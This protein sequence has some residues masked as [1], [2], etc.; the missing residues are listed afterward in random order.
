MGRKTVAAT[1]TTSALAMISCCAHYLANIVPILGI[2]GV[3]SIVA[4]YQIKIFWIG[5][6]SN[7]LGIVFIT[8][9]IIKFPAKGLPAGRQASPFSGGKKTIV[10]KTIIIILLA[11]VFIG[12]F[13][14]VYQSR[15]AEQEI[16]NNQTEKQNSTQNWETKTDGQANVIVAVTP[17]DLAPQSAEW[18]FNVV[19]NTHSIELDQNLA[20][21]AALIDD[22]GKEYKPLR[23][24][25]A[26][27]GGHHRE[28]V[29]VFAP[30]APY[31]QNLALNIKNIGDAQRLFSW[32]LIE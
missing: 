32:T 5:L 28:G 7:I 16:S 19:M 24:E 25:G 26:Q 9:K 8:D 10:N 17:T 1:G 4:Q 14:V 21:I 20:E 31:P 29:L 12:G 23:W 18:K 6:F 30:I 3:L 11:V 13:F 2:A 15:F 22:G 27:A